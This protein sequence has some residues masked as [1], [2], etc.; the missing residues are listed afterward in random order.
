MTQVPDVPLGGLY[1]DAILDH[2]RSPRHRAP[3][4]DPDVQAE[5]YNPFCGDRVALALKLDTRGR[6]V[7]VGANA[8]GCSIIQAAASMVAGALQGKDLG[9]AAAL[10]S[11]FYDVMKGRSLLPAQEQELGDLKSLTVVRDYPVRIKCALLPW[12]A[13]EVGLERYRTGRIPGQ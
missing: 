4:S 2:Y 3:V 8:E 5:E 10:S 6:V 7:Q 1:G 11:L 9:Q 12:T 13:L